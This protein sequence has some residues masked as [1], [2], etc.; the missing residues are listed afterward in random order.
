MLRIHY[1]S[2]LL[3]LLAPACQLESLDA[4]QDGDVSDVFDGG[5]DCDDNDPDVN[6]QATELCDGK[7]NDCDG[8]IDESGAADALF[9]YEDKDSDGYGDS[10]VTTR[11]CIDNV[12]EGYAAADGDCDDLN[13]AVYPTAQEVCNGI[14]DNCNDAIDDGLDEVTYYQDLDGDGYGT[15]TQTTNDCSEALSGYSSVDGDCDDE[16]ETVNPDAIDECDDIDNDCDDALDEDAEEVFDWYAD[17]D[18]DGYGDPEEALEKCDQPS[19]YVD[20]DEDCDDADDSVNPDAEEV[21]YDG[22]DADCDGA[23]DYDA[24]ADGYDAQAYGGE[25][26]DDDDAGFAPNQAD[27]AGDAYDEDCDGYL[28]CYADEDQDGYGD[29]STEEATV[30]ATGGVGD[31]CDQPDLGVADDADDC[32][33]DLDEVNP[34][35]AEVA[36]NAYDDDCNSYVDCFLDA[37]ADGYGSTTIE[38]DV[39]TAT[40]GEA[41]DLCSEGADDGYADDD[42][43]CDDDD[44]TTFPGAADEESST[45]CMR[46]ADGDGW[47]DLEADTGIV[48]G[49][50]CDDGDDT[51]YPG[52]AY[53]DS[54]TA[55]MTDGDG[56]GWGDDSPST[57]SG[58]EDGTDCDDGDAYAFP[59]AA[60]EDSLTECLLD[61]DEDGFGDAS[62]SNPYVGEGTDCDDDDDS[63]YPGADDDYGDYIDQNCDDADG[64]DDDGDGWASTDSLGTD[65]DDADPFTFPAAGD[66]ED[67]DGDGYTAADGDADEED[68]CTTDLDLDGYGDADGSF[69]AG[70]DCDDGNDGFNPG[71]SDEAGDDYDQDCNGLLYCFDDDDDDG[72]GSSYAS[73]STYTATGGVADGDTCGSDPTDGWDDD[74]DDCLDSDDNTHPGAAELESSTSCMTDADGDGW[75]DDGPVSGVTA[76]TD[77][78]DS[79]TL[80]YPGAA[81]LDSTTACMEDY[82]G[83]G[84][85]ADSPS[86]SGAVAGTDCDDKDA[87]S[88]PGV[89]FEESATLCMTDADGDGW[90]DL[91]GVY[92]AGT[93]CDDST[94]ETHPGIQL[95]WFVDSDGDGVDDDDNNCDLQDYQDVGTYAEAQLESVAASSTSGAESVIVPADAG[96]I[97]GDGQMDLAIGTP[98]YLGTRTEQGAAWLFLS[99]TPVSGSVQVSTKGTRLRGASTGDHWGESLAVGDFNTDGLAD[100]AIGAP[101]WSSGDS[102]MVAIVEGS[103]SLSSAN[104]MSAATYLFTGEDTRDY[105]GAAMDAAPDIDGDNKPELVISAPYYD[106]TGAS[107][108]DGRVYIISS[109]N[110]ATMATGTSDISNVASVAIDGDQANEHF[111]FSVAGGADVTTGGTADLLIGAPDGDNS[112]GASAAGRVHLVMGNTN[113]PSMAVDFTFEGD[114]AGDQAGYSVAICDVTGDGNAD[115]LIGAPGYDNGS[116]DEGA[117]YVVLGDPK[118]A[119][120]TGLASLSNRDEAMVLG[121][122]ASGALGTSLACVGDLNGDGIEDWLVGAPGAGPGAEGRTFIIQGGQSGTIEDH[123]VD[124]LGDS[125]TDGT[126]TYVHSLQGYFGVGTHG[127]FFGTDNTNTQTNTASLWSIEP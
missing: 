60:E 38:A 101:D 78:D 117:A 86:V 50:D 5:G 34:G 19:G 6:S 81:E 53:E 31:G 127:L 89:A 80:T 47:G 41:D 25:D 111:G 45:E 94:D 83:D 1:L 76:G 11:A 22:I 126:G 71:E 15:T 124:V 9:V 123:W 13:D 63:I 24:D 82:D 93:D 116:G 107:T 51:T 118:I 97:D 98:D 109:M 28:R 108:D 67:L 59:G 125:S 46:D 30:T 84:Y 64:V 99:G 68:Y 122:E 75:G 110:F 33:D 69:D 112:S 52:A 96:D 27:D 87:Y 37:D 42:D 3:L 70:T 104:I 43:D 119:P 95:D 32:A 91:Y 77:C 49:T 88:Y 26:C 73:D 90:G 102:G 20:N 7:D 44:D 79:T 10:T 21:F 39:Y 106:A 74:S 121:T 100:I 58:A 62:G 14:D 12:P 55:C 35:V 105:L 36:G 48:A 61:A 66:Q 57:A 2:P 18:G 8:Q 56:D 113:Y 4:D 65:C 92:D 29:A 103:S 115:L 17:G 16:D 85:G 72:Y 120:S 114:N 40:Y 23:S 54:T